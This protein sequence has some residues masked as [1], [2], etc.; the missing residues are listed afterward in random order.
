MGFCALPSALDM[1]RGASGSYFIQ[2][3]QDAFDGA[4]F[5]MGI[6]I[7]L[8]PVVWHLPCFSPMRPSARSI[9]QKR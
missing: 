8:A 2:Q 1:L 6:R 3:N 7:H 5:R 9:P 4:I